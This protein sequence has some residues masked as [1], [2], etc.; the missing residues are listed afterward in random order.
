MEEMDIYNGAKEVLALLEYFA[1][2]ILDS[3]PEK[4]NFTLKYLASKANVYVKIDYNKKLNEQKMSEAAKVLISLIYYS[5][6]A[7]DEEKNRIKE[8]WENNN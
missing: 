7:T 5:Y 1:P 3:I 4:F 2:N 6:I 8:N